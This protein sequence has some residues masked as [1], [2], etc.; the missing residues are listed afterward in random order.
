VSRPHP[1][2]DFAIALGFLTV[3]PVG[4]LWPEGGAP[5]AVAYYPWVGWVLGAVGVAIAAVAS[6]F[7]ALIGARGLVVAAVIVTAWALL[8]RLLHWDG[9]ADTAD[10]LWG[11]WTTERRLEIMRD[12]RVGSFAA[13]TVALTAL[14]QVAAVAA[15]LESRAWPWALVC[16]AVLGRASAAWAAWSLKPARREGLGLTAMERPSAWMVGVSVL[17]VVGLLV[18]GHL[19]APRIPFFA[20]LGVGLVAAWLVPRALSRPV[21]GMTGDL[22]GATLLLVETMVLLTGGL[23][24]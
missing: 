21:G 16:A 2:R 13:A 12:S 22:F 10:A 7:G 4:R 9:L 1:V 24:R 17:A 6:A 3:L 5:E 18:L 15:V 14:V 11:G 19:T 20:T 8:T 23:V